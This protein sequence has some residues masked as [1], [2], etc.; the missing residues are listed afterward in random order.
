MERED[1]RR[2]RQ[3]AEDFTVTS[4]FWDAL[5]PSDRARPEK[6]LMLAVLTDAIWD[7]KKNLAARNACFREARAWLF[8]E[9]SEFLF[10]F[11]SICAMLNLNPS[12]IRGALLHL[13]SPKTDS[14][15]GLSLLP[16][17]PVKIKAEK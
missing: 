6:D 2:S 14:L 4:K 16:M 5:Q 11:E 10:S 3:L 12:L 13:E 9:N 7:Y 17:W 8:D 1:S 15:D